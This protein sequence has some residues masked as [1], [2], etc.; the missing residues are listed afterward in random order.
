MREVAALL[1]EGPFLAERLA[2][3]EPFFSA[4]RD[5]MHPVTRAIIEGQ[6]RVIPGSML[7]K[8]MSALWQLRR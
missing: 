3:L 4:H 5:D 8:A 2:G 7:F 1:Y 6:A